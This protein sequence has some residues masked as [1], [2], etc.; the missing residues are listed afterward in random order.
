MPV[1]APVTRIVL[2]CSAFSIQD[3]HLATG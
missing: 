2:F 1:P 3:S